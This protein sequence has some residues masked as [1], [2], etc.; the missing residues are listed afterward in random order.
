MEE[1]AQVVAL[2]PETT[3]KLVAV[4]NFIFQKDLAQDLAITF[5]KLIE[6]PLHV[7][8]DLCGNEG[9][10]EI[11]A[12]IGRVDEAA[13]QLIVAGVRAEELAHYVVANRIHEGA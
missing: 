4:A 8:F 7:L 5:R 10:V 1:H 6:D 9:A 2:D 13:V 11:G 12:A 3:A